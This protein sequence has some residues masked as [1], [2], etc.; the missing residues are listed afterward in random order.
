MIN[1]LRTDFSCNSILKT[2]QVKTPSILCDTNLS[3]IVEYY[4]SCKSNDLKPVISYFGDEVYL[5]RN[6][7]EYNDLLKSYSR[8]EISS[9]CLHIVGSPFGA[10]ANLVTES[11]FPYAP[12]ENAFEIAQKYLDEYR[13]CDIVL[14]VSPYEGECYEGLR[15]LMRDV[16]AEAGLK[17]CLVDS[18]FYST[19][20]KENVSDHR[21]I[22]GYK[23]KVLLKNFTNMPQEYQR[24][25]YSDQYYVRDWSHIPEFSITREIYDSCEEYNILHDPQ[26]PQIDN[27]MEK[28]TELCREGY[29]EKELNKRANRQVYVDRIKEELDVIEES[30]FAGYFLILH[31]LCK[32]VDS[33]GWLRG[34]SRGSAAGCILLWL[35]D[36]TKVDPVQY[37]LLFDRFFNLDRAKAKQLPDC[38]LDVP[39]SARDGVL[40]YL[41]EKYGERCVAKMATYTELQGRSALTTVMHY[42]QTA[43]F[44]EIKQI[45]SL[46]PQKDKVTDKLENTGETSLIRYVL[47][48]TPERLSNYA[49]LEDGK[50]VG[51][52]AA[53]FE[54]AIRLEGT[55][56]QI[57]IHASAIIVAD[58]P[59]ETLAP[60]MWDVKKEEKIVGLTLYDGE[61]VGLLKIDVLGLQNLDANKI[62]LDLVENG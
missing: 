35:T 39:K 54:Q 29:K 47:E 41:N 33:Q 52:Y 62:A 58:K 32:W 20:S 14:A 16:A 50:I 59:I 57:G 30:G 53:D 42:N 49:R 8:D 38:D 45:T 55:R 36:V 24:F 46:L 12:K 7:Q 9:S 19:N 10:L 44:D 11:Y 43:S 37:K 51:D 40:N 56:T 25:F 18:V 6:K 3:S 31:D 60:L 27:A 15:D 5:A 23:S 4:N 48:Y 2:R 21:I 13:D 17:C 61:A 28:L 26:L 22:C 1:F 34:F